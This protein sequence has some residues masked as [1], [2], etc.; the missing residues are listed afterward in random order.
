LQE[1]RDISGQEVRDIC[2]KR[3]IDVGRRLEIPEIKEE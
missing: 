3:G 2:R 1:R